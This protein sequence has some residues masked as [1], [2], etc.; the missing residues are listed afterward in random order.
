MSVQ[1]RTVTLAGTLASTGESPLR[2]WASDT[3]EVDVGTPPT[4]R[5]RADG[6]SNPS[7]AKR[8]PGAG[9]ISGGEWMER[10][11]RLA[12]LGSAASCDKPR[13]K[14]LAAVTLTPGSNNACGGLITPWRVGA[15]PVGSVRVGRQ[16]GPSRS[17]R[18]SLHQA[19]SRRIA[20]SPESRMLDRTPLPVTS[21]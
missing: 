12:H 4:R 15:T 19:M 18:A 8:V 11:T 3:A 7:G 10:C 5:R 21:H 6:W 9:G 2:D 16:G 20:Q 14:R 17:R 1:T 13:K